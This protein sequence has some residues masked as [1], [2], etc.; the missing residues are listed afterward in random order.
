MAAPSWSEEPLQEWNDDT[1]EIWRQEFVQ[2]GAERRKSITPQQV[3][4][5]MNTSA[6]RRKQLR[7]MDRQTRQVVADLA[8]MVWHDVVARPLHKWQIWRYQLNVASE[9]RLQE[10]DRLVRELVRL[11]RGWIAYGSDPHTYHGDKRYAHIEPLPET[12]LFMSLIGNGLAIHQ[13]RSSWT[14]YQLFDTDLVPAQ[15]RN[16][17]SFRDMSIQEMR[18]LRSWLFANGKFLAGRT[19]V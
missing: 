11:D 13:S 10:Y 3:A 5:A 9:T 17:F 14:T 15:A 8:D 18:A 16:P 19:G 6:G 12:W 2:A 7:S 4:A 1:F